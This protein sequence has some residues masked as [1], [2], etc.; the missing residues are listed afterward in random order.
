MGI[1]LQFK[2]LISWVNIYIIVYMNIQKT[3][4]SP[5]ALPFH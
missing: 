4:F 1:K 3:F 5:V 2:E